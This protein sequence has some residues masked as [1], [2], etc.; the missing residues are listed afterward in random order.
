MSEK[1]KIYPRYTEDSEI[2]LMVVFSHPSKDDMEEKMFGKKG[3]SAEEVLNA[4]S[5]SNISTDRFKW[6]G[7]SD[8]VVC[9]AK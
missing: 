4:L 2:D 9:T 1:I 8:S 3:A 7:P 6:S 5:S